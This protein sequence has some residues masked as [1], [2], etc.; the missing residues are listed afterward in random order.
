MKTLLAIL[1]AAG[2]AVGSFTAFAQ[3]PAAP[4]P[5]APAP[6]AP[7]A[8]TTP[9][10]TLKMLQAIRDQNAK[11]LEQQAATLKL[12]EEM[13]KTSNQLKFFGKRS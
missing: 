11:L 9:A 10:E 4:A 13:E 3:A 6:V 12:L 8:P 7:G 5:A 1:S 2:L